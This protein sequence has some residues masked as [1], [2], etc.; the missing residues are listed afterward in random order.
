LLKAL[1]NKSKKGKIMKKLVLMLATVF[2]LA[3][4][5]VCSATAGKVLD[6]EMFIVDKF[7]TATNYKA[8]EPMLDAE[9]K[10]DFSEESFNKFRE[11]I[12]KNFGTLNS[13]TLRFIT[14]MDD[15]D[16]L[17]YQAS[18]SNVP[19]AAYI[20]DF[21]VVK[22]KPLVR[23]FEIILPPKEQPAQNN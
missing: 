18:F 6:N 7:V 21:S 10:K 4:C 14:K 22:E 13:K 2:M 5:S 9:Y 20:F 15:A 23:N 17:E 19:V 1:V 11:I 12:A 16:R 3:F 8:I